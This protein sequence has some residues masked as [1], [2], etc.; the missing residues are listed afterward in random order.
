MRDAQSLLDQAVAFSGQDIRDDD[1]KEILGTIDRELLF[2][3][4]TLILGQDAGGGLLARRKGHG[5]GLRPPRLLQ[6]PHPAFPEPAAGQIGRRHRGPA[7]SQ[8]R[9]DRRPQGGS[10]QGHGGGD[11]ALSPGPAG[12]RAGAPVFLPP[13]DLSGDAARQAEPFQQ[14]HAPPGPGPRSRAAEGQRVRVRRAAGGNSLRSASGIEDLAPKAGT[15]P[16]LRGRTVRPL[17]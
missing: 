7:A 6:R 8:C 17:G 15:L 12:G 14:D 3:G 9:R 1:L 11:A 4:S 13:P 2:A 16:G 10:R 5:A